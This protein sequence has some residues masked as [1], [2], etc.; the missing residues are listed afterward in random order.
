MVSSS[1]RRRGGPGAHLACGAAARRVG[2]A[3]LGV[4]ITTGCLV[5]P[6]PDFE[7]TKTRPNLNL[8]TISPP[9]TQIL[10]LNSNEELSISAQVQSEDDGDRLFGQLYLNWGLPGERRVLTKTIDPGTLA[11]GDRTFL[12]TWTVGADVAD[13]CHQLT[14]LVTHGSNVPPDDPQ[15]PTSTEDVAYAH[16]WINVNPELGQQQTLVNCPGVGSSPD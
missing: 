2:L 14:F 13:G 15:R 6:P 8:D 7:T 4:L 10:V 12:V 5:S 3:L 1:S 16:W 9:V 11:D